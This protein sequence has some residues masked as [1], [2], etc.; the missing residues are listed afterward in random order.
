MIKFN[1]KYN[2]NDFLD[3]IND[4]L[5]TDYLPN[6]EDIVINKTRYKEITKAKVLGF[7]ESLNLY[8]LEMNHSREKD[9]RVTI[10][11]DAFKILADHWIHQAI[12]IFRNSESNNYRLSY[13]TISLDLNDKNKAV[14]KYSN[15]HRYSFYL[16]VNAKTK[17]PEQQLLGKGRVTN[18]Q[19]LFER[20]SVEVV[21]KE[22][23]KEIAKFFSRLTGGERKFG[24]KTL[25]FEPEMILPSVSSEIGKIHQEF[26]VRLIGRI[27]FCWFLKQKKSDKGISLLPDEFLSSQAVK[28]NNDYYHS[29]IEPIFFEV[30]NKPREMRKTQFRNGYDRIPY[31]NGGLFDPHVDD[32]YEGQPNYSLKIPNSWFKD[33]YEILETYNFT[34]DE[35]T[36]LDVDL[37][38]DPEMLGRIF[39][40][41]LAEINP[42]TGE[43]AR[44][45]TGSYYT[46][47]QIVDYMVD[48][49]LIQYLANKT[50]ISESKIKA[51]VS[52]DELDDELYPLNQDEKQKIVCALDDLKVIDPACGSGAF[53]ISI[54]QKV[55]FLLNKTDP[56]GKLWFQRK[57]SDLD[58][59]VYEF[60]RR[61]FENENFDYIRKTGIIRDSI[62]GV[63][64]Q[65]IAVEVSKLRCFLTLVVDAEIDDTDPINRGIQPLPN[66]E[67]K[68]VAANTLINL[69]G[70]SIANN[71]QMEMFESKDEI[72]ELKKI[73]DQY[74]VSNGLQKER[75]KIEFDKARIKMFQS[76]RD[77]HFKGTLTNAL[78]DWD[79]FGYKS[80]NWFD[81]EWMF[82][83]QN[84]DIVIANPPYGLINKKQNQKLGH[85][86]SEAESDLY[87]S[88][89]EYKPA[90]QGVVNVYKL[91]V[92]KSLNLLK[93]NGC[94]VEIFPLSFIA[95]STCSKLRKFLLESTQ[96]V[97]IEAFPERDN[98]KK[99]VFEAV[100]MSVCILILKNN[101]ANQS[102]FFLRK[103]SDRFIDSNI[104]PNWLSHEDIALIDSS[105]YTLPLLPESEFELIK[106][107]YTDKLRFSEVGHCYTGEID[108]TIC[109]KYIT[110]DSLRS[111]M[112]K[113]AAIDRY[114]IK[115][116]MSQGEIEYLDASSYLAEN[117]GGKS[118]HH[119]MPRIVMQ[120]ITGVNEK[121]RIKCARI[122]PEIFC[123][124]SV[125]YLCLKKPDLEI[126]YIL[127]LMNSKLINYIFAKT[128]TNS[129]VNGYEVDNLPIVVGDKETQVQIAQMVDKIMANYNSNINSLSKE[130]DNIVYRL[131]NLAPEEIKIIEE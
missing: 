63:D 29:V 57:F 48:Q 79:P 108:M 116:K 24:S 118:S 96:I 53:P 60:Y 128:S 35:N 84:F 43:S 73:R 92:L 61:K 41:L 19:D 127:G 1:E 52:V 105:N 119:K 16:G 78:A 34:I 69:P 120:G 46:P 66:L 55:V 109:K 125:N 90:M 36:T 40:N 37:S 86:T 117:H 111:K 87:K 32:Y 6:E 80:S 13:L 17:T 110:R 10:A 9:P 30:L 15:A 126:G 49:S 129:N 95:D 20:F 58:S 12:V 94:F 21:N 4:F 39:E 83:V 89:A 76:Q 93:K 113:G 74:F 121:I 67:F 56:C 104:R 42:E 101:A 100:K 3:F 54:L 82:G 51:I 59:L 31:L 64:I 98:P 68:F 45:S 124:N 99:R 44:K 33:L 106:K 112:I 107:I 122:E 70:S 65:P 88:N 115:D 77:K 103:N 62:Y 7:S 5:P 47:R 75:W 114:L 130:I 2:Q 28:D 11:T 72:N 102:E 50:E 71:G 91:F 38:I 131:Y 81:S 123:A 26:T 8:V 14:K 27:I 25:H 22:F 23:Y 85:K 18:Q 97:G